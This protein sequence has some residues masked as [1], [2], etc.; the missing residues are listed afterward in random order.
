[1]GNS[2]RGL[3]ANCGH[4]GTRV[5]QRKRY[6]QSS[7]LQKLR[8]A[9]K[10]TLFIEGFTGFVPAVELAQ[11]MARHDG[12]GLGSRHFIDLALLVVI[13]SVETA[14]S[15]QGQRNMVQHLPEEGASFL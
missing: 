4:L 6:G 15:H 1:M 13:L 3:Q 8:F 2:P 12:H 14:L 7:S 5:H 10:E 11:K 9:G